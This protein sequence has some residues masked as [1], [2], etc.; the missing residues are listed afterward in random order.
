MNVFCLKSSLISVHDNSELSIYLGSV[1]Q[2]SAISN[3][4]IVQYRAD[5]IAW[6]TTSWTQTTRINATHALNNE[7]GCVM[8][9]SGRL[10]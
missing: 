9:C 3:K 8:I 6:Y 1:L 7:E 5:P 2:M 10:Q 4:P